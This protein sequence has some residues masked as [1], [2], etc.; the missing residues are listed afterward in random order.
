MDVNSL[1]VRILSMRVARGME[2]AKSLDG[3]LMKN[4]KITE[5]S[6]R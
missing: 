6:K 5:K 3:K 4:N 1:I 2:M